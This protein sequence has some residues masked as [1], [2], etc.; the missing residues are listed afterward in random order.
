[1]RKLNTL[2]YLIIFGLVLPKVKAKSIP[3]SKSE[4]LSS[5]LDQ[6]QASQDSSENNESKLELISSS[7]VE[8]IQNVMNVTRRRNNINRVNLYSCIPTF[9]LL[10]MCIKI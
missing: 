4:E 1:M 5:E 6:P 9:F 3:Y 7:E 8:N 10:P 2:I